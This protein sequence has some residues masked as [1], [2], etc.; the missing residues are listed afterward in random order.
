MDVVHGQCRGT[1]GQ[2]VINQL[3]NDQIRYIYT[4][5][6]RSRREAPIHQKYAVA[7]RRSGLLEFQPAVN[8]VSMSCRPMFVFKCTTR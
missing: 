5:A 4:A 8:C 3:R 6:R 1:H 7:W 2:T